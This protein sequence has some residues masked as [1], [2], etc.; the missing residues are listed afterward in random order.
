MLQYSCVVLGLGCVEFVGGVKG[1]GC[2]VGGG[3]SGLWWMGSMRNLSEV[4]NR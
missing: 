1:S 3:V 2:N 4:V